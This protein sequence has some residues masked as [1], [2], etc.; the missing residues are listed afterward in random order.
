MWH[1]IF[2]REHVGHVNKSISAKILNFLL[3]IYSVGTRPMRVMI[4]ALLHCAPR[5]FY[6]FYF[7]PR[8]IRSVF[9]AAHTATGVRHVTGVQS[10][11]KR[12]IITDYVNNG[13]AFFTDTIALS[14]QTSPLAWLAQSVEHETLN[15]G[16]VGSSPTLGET[17]LII[18]PSRPYP[19][20]SV[21]V[22]FSHFQSICASHFCHQKRKVNRSN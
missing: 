7:D 14:F 17:F 6:T 12:P 9:H 1:F 21:H 19:E 5:A 13:H 4:L 20:Q 10:S 16:V 11:W 18:H 22:L 8:V 2:N 3:V 15:L